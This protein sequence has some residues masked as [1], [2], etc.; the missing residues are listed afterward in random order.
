MNIDFKDSNGVEV[1]L[2]DRVSYYEL[3]VNLSDACE[4]YDV[5]PENNFPVNEIY[6][7]KK[8]G[9]VE[10][11]DCAFRVNGVVLCE[12]GK[13]IIGE[14]MD[15]WYCGNLQITL[16]EFINYERERFDTNNVTKL[17][18]RVDVITN[19]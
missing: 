5:E 16:R 11:K 14:V 4:M 15:F 12:L 17:I 13:S 1:K 9:I 10:Y 8:T 6:I 19:N 3:Y 7:E 2:G 18:K